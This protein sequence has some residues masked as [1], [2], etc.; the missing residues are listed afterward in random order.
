[1]KRRTFVA[2]I[3]AMVVPPSITY[4][5]SLARAHRLGIL[6]EGSAVSDITGPTPSASTIRELL[7]R[8][9]ELGYRYGENLATEVRSAEGRIDRFPLLATELVQTKPSAIVVT[10]NR[11]AM[12]AKGATTTTPVVM[13]GISDPIGFGL[14]TSLS[15]PG[16]NLTG[17]TLDTGP[18]FAAKRLELLKE[19]SPQVRRVAYFIP[20]LVWLERPGGRAIQQAALTL[21]MTLLPIVVTTREEIDAADAGLR[22][23]RPDALLVEAY[24]L[25]WVERRRLSD[26]GLSHRL[27]TMFANQQIVE[28]G[29][30]LSYSTDF[31]AVYRRAAEYVDRILKGTKA[32]DLPIEQPTK[33]Q[34]AI[35]LKTARAIALT[36]PP[37]LLARADRVIE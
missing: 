32:G 3:A 1:M 34:V 24:V 6:A 33:F 28:A 7:G 8:L 29:G 25:S 10:S 16:G 31:N 19:L 21:G 2:T 9:H 20:T 4:A 27:P 11:A 12:A 5:Q 18:D 15:R 35:N 17:I 14:V 36:I 26:L 23:Q 13:A 37:S 30:L 22:S